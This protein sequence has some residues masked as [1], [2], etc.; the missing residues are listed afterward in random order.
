M[1]AYA[2]LHGQNPNHHFFARCESLTRF[3]GV[4]LR[5]LSST[6]IVRARR[7]C[8]CPSRYAKV[9]LEDP[10]ELGGGGGGGH[11]KHD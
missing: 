11:V 9:Q 8:C 1:N 2:P 5:L 7:G 3:D 4:A 10:D 6:P